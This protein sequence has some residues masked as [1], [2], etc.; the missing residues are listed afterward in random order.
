MPTIESKITLTNCYHFQNGMVMAFDQYGKQ[1]PEYQGRYEEVIDKIRRD[2]P[3]V[4]IQG[5]VWR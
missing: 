1:M 2:F 3:R 5:A 4:S